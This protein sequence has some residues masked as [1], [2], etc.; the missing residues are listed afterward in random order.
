M[1]GQPGFATAMGDHHDAPAT[2]RP[3]VDETAQ[4]QAPEK[5]HQVVEIFK[6][7]AQI[8]RVGV[9]LWDFEP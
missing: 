4:P 1:A 7:H 2:L 5:Q 3:C 9:R 6:T 8:S